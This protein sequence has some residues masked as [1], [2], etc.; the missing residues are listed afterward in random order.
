MFVEEA[1]IDSD[2]D[3]PPQLAQFVV[4]S[5]CMLS[6]PFPCI[7]RFTVHYSKLVV[8]L[9]LPSQ[10]STVSVAS[11]GRRKFLCNTLLLGYLSRVMR[12][13]QRE[14]VQVESVCD[15]E[16]LPKREIPLTCLDATPA[17][18]AH[19][20]RRR[21]FILPLLIALLRSCLRPTLSYL[22]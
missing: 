18:N 17:F 3:F 6:L 4:Q 10:V 11:E 12:P 2:P 21:K 13:I 8:K 5:L 14:N 16:I 1:S 22:I 9:M 15:T 20:H 19:T 7:S